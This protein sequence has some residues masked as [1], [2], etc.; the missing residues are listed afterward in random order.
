MNDRLSKGKS[1]FTLREFNPLARF[2]TFN[3][4]GSGASLVIGFGASIGLA[5]WLGPS[6]RGLLGL[7]ISA[8]GLALALTSVG[9]PLSVVYFASRRDAEPA[10]IFGDTLL[11]AVVL[12]ALF[13]PV[14]LLFHR[15]LAGAV[16]HGYG[17]DTWV[18]AAALVPIVFLD[19]T[20]HGQLQGMMRF[21]R[22]NVLL[23]V[24]RVAYALAIVMLLGVFD[25]GVAGGLIA[26]AVASGVM[27]V[28]SLK[29]ILEWGAPRIDGE[30]LRRMLHYGTRV[31]VGAI[32]QITNAR[33]DVIILQFY[34]QL[35]QVGYY[36]VAQTI[37]ELVITLARAFQSSVLPLASRY[38]GDERQAATSADSILHHGILAAAAVLGNAVFGSI[39]IFFAFGPQFRP[40]I[41]P[42][43]ILLPGIWFLGAGMV[44][45]GDL[46]GR[47]R[48]GLSSLLAGLA[49]GVTI[50][51]DFALIPPLGV[52]GATLASV[53][54]YTTFGVASLIALHR[55]S[56]VPL[57]RLVV[58]TREDFALYSTLLARTIAR[59][60]G[61]SRGK[62]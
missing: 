36:V 52:L 24:S 48:P 3:V 42:M 16:S 11:Y 8:S 10:K 5:R 9:L 34:R 31:Q 32:L 19:W 54:A 46:G 38:Q 23:V 27:V 7:M 1:L 26:T 20:T 22:F 59:I 35:S 18:F 49:A 12:T 50:V 43:L 58:P 39:V 2:V 4:V 17:G 21:G 45:Q 62:A 60:R 15:Q 33:L 44:I 6:G 40:A 47:N 25:L 29:P 55:V 61:R 37:A 56:G 14:G 13:I 28:G 57:R 41:V 53:A 30:L 51:L